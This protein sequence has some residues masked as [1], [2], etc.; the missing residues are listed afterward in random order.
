MSIGVMR[1]PAVARRISRLRVNYG[2][3]SRVGLLVEAEDLHGGGLSVED[4]ESS[5]DESGRVR[6]PGARGRSASR[7]MASMAA[8]DA[9]SAA[10]QMMTR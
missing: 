5:V 3:D 1:F 7:A 10:R 6:A 8:W 4:M 2:A 9:A